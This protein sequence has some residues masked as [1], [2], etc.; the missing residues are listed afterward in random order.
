MAAGAQTAALSP[1]AGLLRRDGERLGRRSRAR[2][3]HGARAG[4]QGG[5]PA[6]SRLSARRRHVHRPRHERGIV[7]VPPLDLGELHAHRSNRRRHRL[8]MGGRRR[9]R[10]AEDRFRES[11]QHGDRESAAV[12]ESRRARAGSVHRDPGAAGGRRPRESARGC[13]ASSARRRGTQR[14]R[15][16]GREQDRRADRGS[17][18]H[19]HLRSTGLAATVAA[20]HSGRTAVES[21]AVDRERG[22]EGALL[23][24]VLGAEAG[25]RK[26]LPAPARSRCSV[27]L[28]RR[29]R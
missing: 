29:R 24:A 19:Y 5:R 18:R 10:L 12:E 14:V 22:V 2:R 8:G 26:R 28:R 21:D 16:G 1:R 20:V 9:Q 6:G 4:T 3:A 23:H 11:Q 27:A 7:R 17:A 15:Q 25:G 13:A